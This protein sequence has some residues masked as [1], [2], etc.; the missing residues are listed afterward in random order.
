MEPLQASTVAS[1]KHFYDQ[2]AGP[3]TTSLLFILT[4]I[5]P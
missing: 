1:F 2:L 4:Y 3:I 5:M